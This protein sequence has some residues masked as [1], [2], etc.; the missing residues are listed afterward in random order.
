MLLS[1]LMVNNNVS[2]FLIMIIVLI[3]LISTQDIIFLIVKMKIVD[4][5]YFKN[6]HV[7]QKMNQLKLS[8]Q[9]IYTH[10]SKPVLTIIVNHLYGILN[11]VVISNA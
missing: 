7:Q 11:Q 3:L 10:V 2:S 5:A 1:K 8:F 6:Q 9:L 4:N